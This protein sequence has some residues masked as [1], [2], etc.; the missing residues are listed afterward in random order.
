MT[1][2]LVQPGSRRA[3]R[4]LVRAAG[5]VCPARRAATRSSDRLSRRF[6]VSTLVMLRRMHDAGGLSRKRFWEAY[7]AE[8]ERILSIPRNSGGNFYLSQ[9]ARVS[10]RFARAIIMTTW[11]GRSSFTEAFRLLGVRRMES[12]RGMSESLGMPV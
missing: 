6:K 4:P 2:T 9:S 5:H 11:E 8:L 7:R 10:K 3:A 12:F 1:S